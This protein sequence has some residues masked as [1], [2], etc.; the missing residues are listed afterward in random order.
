MIDTEALVAE[1]LHASKVAH[2]AYRRLLKEEKPA[3]ARLELANAARLR[4]EAYTADPERSAPAWA[5][6]QGRTPKA[7]DTHTTLSAFYAQQL[8]K[9]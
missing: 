6:E 4:D 2:E 5:L 8:A 3:A 9:S 7:L 1:K